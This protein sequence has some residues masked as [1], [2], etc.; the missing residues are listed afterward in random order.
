MP[1]PPAPANAP[2]PP[3]PP[4]G[5]QHLA[6]FVDAIALDSNTFE[7]KNKKNG[8]TFM[9]TRV[10]NGSGPSG[11]PMQ[12]KVDSV[13]FVSVPTDKIKP[14]I[15]VNGTIMKDLDLNKINPNAIES[16]NVLKG[17]KALAKYADQGANGVVEI[18]TKK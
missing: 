16:I 17:A 3:T 14:L 4:K 1:P 7:F 12:I 5:I 6:V 8:T 11:K 13:S 18:T 9:A 10:A 15:V 2:T